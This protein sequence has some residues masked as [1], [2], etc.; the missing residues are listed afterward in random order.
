VVEPGRDGAVDFMTTAQGVLTDLRTWIGL[1]SWAILRRD[2]NDLIVMLTNDETFGLFD[3]LTLPWA[4]SYLQQVVEWGRPE[5]VPDAAENLQLTRAAENALAP[6]GSTVM[7]PLRSPDGKILGALTGLN[8]QPVADLDRHL[9]AVRRQAALLGALLG[10]ELW[11]QQEHRRD[12]VPVAEYTDLL[13]GLANRRAWDDALRSEDARAAR[14][15]GSVAVL[16]LDLDGLRRVNQGSAGHVGGDEVLI[17]TAAVLAG[18]MRSVDFVARI[19]GDEFGVLMP[20]TTAA[21]A[22]TVLGDLRKALTAAGIAA[23]FGIGQ[24]RSNTG[25]QAAWR[26]ADVEMYADKLQSAGRLV[27]RQ[28]AE[29]PTGP[30]GEPVRP[31]PAEHRGPY[32]GPERRRPRGRA[33]RPAAGAEAAGKKIPEPRGEAPEP[34]TPEQAA[35]DVAAA[36]AALAGPPPGEALTEPLGRRL[37]SVDALLQLA[38]DQLGMEVACL[39]VFEGTTGQHRVRNL[40]AS[41]PVPLVVGQ[42]QPVD[43]TYCKAIADGRMNV[44]VPDTSRDPLARSLAMTSQLSIGSHVGVPLRR[45]D[46]RLYGTLCTWSEH[47][48]EALRE[49]DA[50]VLRAIGTVVM[51]LVDIEDRTERDRHKMLIRMDRLMANGG[52]GVVF[53]A[54]HALDGLTTVGVEALSRFP[55]GSGRPDEWFTSATRAGVGLELE[56]AAVRNAL[57]ILPALRGFLGINVS[58]RTLVSPS[59][60]RLVTALPLKSIVI[61]ITEHEAVDDYDAL[62]EVLRPWRE[63]GMRVAVD[64]A[65]AGFASMRHVL[66]LVPDFI[67]LDI[68]LVRGIDTDPAKRALAG[69]L[70]AFAQKIGSSVIAEGIET[71]P[72]LSCL[73]SLKVEFGQGYHLSLPGPLADEMRK[74]GE[75]L[76]A[77]LG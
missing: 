57:T 33:G 31:G 74:D 63:R 65:G 61:E 5:A 59:F 16:V 66:T 8:V 12:H 32:F 49:R 10:H 77:P 38:R 76:P 29:Q 60:G 39:G 62:N 69:A 71:A 50:E 35:A 6:V 15:A 73:R 75:V 11:T 14:Y 43:D 22:G 19:G 2:D 7:V 52:P 13:T 48:D 72:E 3:G 42:I 9:P 28:A 17:T 67:K 51:D 21:E 26:A 20:E 23:A 34:L 68:S 36:G 40:V 30:G 41:T 44:V 27:P 18:R 47:P 4:D 58:P 53:Q 64:D 56:L 45:R 54:V 25:L 1:D 46:G 37:T 70:A 24:R 55:A